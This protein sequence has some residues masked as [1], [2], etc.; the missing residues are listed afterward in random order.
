MDFKE[1]IRRNMPVFVI[2]GITAFIFLL[3]ILLAQRKPQSQT[4]LIEVDNIDLI[5]PHTYVKGPIGAPIDIVEFTDFGCPACKVM[6]PIVSRVVNEYSEYVRFG[7][8]HFP[9]PQHK[10]AQNAAIA[11]QAAGEQGKFW[12]YA[13]VLFQNQGKFE[14]E[15][16]TNYAD[17]LGLDNA[18]FLKDFKDKA[19]KE[20]VEEDINYGRKIG[21]NATPTFF[22]NGKQILLSDED[23]L[24]YAI[25]EILKEKNINI[26]EIQAEQEKEQQELEQNTI[27]DL[28]RTVDQVYGYLDI[29]YTKEG[30]KPLNA[31]ATA[32]QVLRLANKTENDI[33]FKQL[34]PIFDDLREPRQIK[35]GETMEYRFSLRKSGTWTYEI[36]GDTNRGQIRIKNAPQ[37]LL[38]MLPESVQ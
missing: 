2:G 21:I 22:I 25:E 27:T 4:Q 33:S 6:H 14:D 38:R 16:L 8:R 28:F 7:V 24:K 15:D 19:F 23:T 29:E 20:L 32:G 35:A 18:Q 31:Q 3:I 5:S 12:E 26:G 37:E 11:A 1:L 30:L 13:D 17:Y 9:L 10:N 34:M 36:E